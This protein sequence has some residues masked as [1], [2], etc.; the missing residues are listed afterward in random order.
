M[1]Y[2]MR[3]LFRKLQRWKKG[4][5]SCDVMIVSISGAVA[6]E[7]YEIVDEFAMMNQL[8]QSRRSVAASAMDMLIAVGNAV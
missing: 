3:K 2:P 6:S 5:C 1:I 7:K 8:K 4:K